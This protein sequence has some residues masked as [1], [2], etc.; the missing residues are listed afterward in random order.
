MRLFVPGSAD[1]STRFG[2]S[3]PLLLLTKHTKQSFGQKLSIKFSSSLFVIRVNLLHPC[4]LIVYCKLLSILRFSS[5][6]ITALRRYSQ[7]FGCDN[8]SSLTGFSKYQT[9]PGQIPIFVTFCKQLPLVSDRDQIIE[10]KLDNMVFYHYRIS[11]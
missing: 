11:G 7:T 10:R 3:R 2:L 9:F 5:L 8:L 4:F 1:H 6:L